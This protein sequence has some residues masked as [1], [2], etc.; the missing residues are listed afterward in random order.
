MKK[1]ILC[2][3]L[4][5]SMLG[6]VGCAKKSEPS[7]SNPTVE[8]KN[9]ENSVEAV[10]FQPKKEVEVVVP[11]SAG[12]GSDLHARM[13][14]DISQ[15]NKLSPKSFMVNN[16]PG[17]AGAVAHAPRIDAHAGLLDTARHTFGRGAGFDFQLQRRAAHSH[18]R[19]HPPRGRARQR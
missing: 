19:V 18:R 13:F 4:A 8:E 7:S 10:N 1:K 5:I 17:G 11:S 6:I 15:K 2:V 12:G 9:E 3:V 14:A 16:M